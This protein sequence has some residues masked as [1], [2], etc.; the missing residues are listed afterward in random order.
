MSRLSGEVIVCD[1]AAGGAI[2]LRIFGDEFYAR[3][4]TLSGY[5]VIYDKSLGSYCYVTLVSG[6]FVSTGVG[7][8]NPAPEGLAKHLQEDAAIKEQKFEQHYNHLRPKEIDLGSIS[9]ETFGVDQGLLDG[10]KLSIGDVVGLTIIVEFADVRTHISREAVEAMFNSDGYRANGN[11]CSVK[12]YFQIISSGKLHY[13]NVVVGPIRLAQNRSYY[14]HNRL[15]KEALD[16]AVREYDLDL[17]QFDSRGEGTVD[18]INILYAGRSEYSGWLWPHNS[19]AEYE[20]DGILTHYYQIAGVGEYDIDLSIGT[21]CHENG[22][23]LCRFPDLYDYGKRDGDNKK[24]T[25]LGKYC[26]M[27]SGNYLNYGKTPSPVCGYLRD[28]AGWVDEVV[29]LEQSHRVEAVHGDYG[30]LWKHDTHLPNEYFLVENRSRLGL[31]KYLPSSGLAIY[32]CDILGSNEWQEGT[33]DKHY[34]CALMQADGRLDLESGRSADRTDLY[35]DVHGV[36]ISDTTNPSSRTWSGSDSG[37]IISEV[38]Q[39][40]ETMRFSVGAAAETTKIAMETYPALAI[41]DND[42]AGVA[43]PMVIDAG[44]SVGQISVS[45]YVMHNYLGDLEVSLIAPDGTSVKL[46]DHDA[47]GDNDIVLAYNSREFPPLEALV[48]RDIR[49]EWRLHVTDTSSG[50]VG[51]LTWWS[52]EIFLEN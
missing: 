1:Q 12:E 19:V 20:Y 24:S 3:Y 38:S 23:M 2:Q 49:G 47:V 31:D 34:Q 7:A 39:P 37:L 4:E 16:K 11:Y 9:T 10:R 18:A 5:S 41:T 6:R 29:P 35:A 52:I 15:V 36:A 14:I 8:E 13:T 40:G 27:G 22:H 43:S 45:F 42:P 44:G 25:G 30:R 17:S 51:R 28:L 32:H 33:G 50:D 26:L 21:I 46:F 48:G